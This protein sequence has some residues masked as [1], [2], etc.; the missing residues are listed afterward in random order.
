MANGE[1][2]AMQVA[3]AGLERECFNL[4]NALAA[5]SADGVSIDAPDT[6]SSEL[7]Y[8]PA[9]SDVLPPM[10]S[11][12][13]QNGTADDA[14]EPPPVLTVRDLGTGAIQKT[15]RSL[16]GELIVSLSR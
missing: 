2:E 11:P 4:R 1:K 6:I 15:H 13:Q 8:G 5:A 9:A 16:S 3:V 10:P 7:G 14:D 12:T